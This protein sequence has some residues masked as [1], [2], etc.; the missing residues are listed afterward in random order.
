MIQE[1]DLFSLFLNNFNIMYIILLVE[2]LVSGVLFAVSKLVKSPKV[3]KVAMFL[4]KQ[5][6]LTLVMFSSLNIAVSAGMH[7]KYSSPSDSMYALSS[8]C[9]YLG[10]AL[11]LATVL[12]LELAKEKGYGEFKDKFKD[13][14][15]CKF[16]ITVSIAF[17][18]AI[19][20]FIPLEDAFDEG[21]LLF[22]SLFLLYFFLTRPFHQLFHNIRAGIIHCSSFVTLLVSVYYRVSA[23]SPK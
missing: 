13:K 2:L 6:L 11:C 16:Y 21:C 7:W 23:E 20:I 3:K 19:G 12:G 18:V 8:A 5:G 9:L 14:K 17:R 10:L 4:L 22:M 1:L 15:R